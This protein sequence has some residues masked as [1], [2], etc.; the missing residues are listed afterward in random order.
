MTLSFVKTRLLAE[1]RRKVDRIGEHDVY[2]SEVFVARKSNK[3]KGKCNNC[4]KIGH[5][6]KDCRLKKSYF[7]NEL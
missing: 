7:I 3:F 2:K 4:G 6:R 1:E 5:I